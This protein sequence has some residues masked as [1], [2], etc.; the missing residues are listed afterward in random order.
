MI[1]RGD[2]GTKVDSDIFIDLVVVVIACNKI[3][4]MP[5]QK[6]QTE[7]LTFAAFIV[8]SI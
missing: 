8:K 7:P 3:P 4:N 2:G 6:K 1:V 5:T